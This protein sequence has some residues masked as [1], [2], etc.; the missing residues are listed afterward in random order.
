MIVNSDSSQYSKGII[1]CYK[2]MNIFNI[3]TVIRNAIVDNIRE[4]INL[5]PDIFFLFLKIK[6]TTQEAFVLN[7]PKNLFLPKFDFLIFYS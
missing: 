4:M 3:I 1:I 6:M 5:S 2:H 7:E